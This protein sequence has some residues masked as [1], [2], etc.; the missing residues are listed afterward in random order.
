M[1]RL[2]TIIRKE[3]EEVFRNKMVLASVAL[4][5]L[6]F[7]GIALGTLGSLSMVEMDSA[8]LEADSEE[9]MQLAGALCEGMGGAECLQAYMGGLMMSLFL[10]LPVVLP[11]VF[12]AYSVVGEKTSRTLEPL[13]ATPITTTELLGGKAIAAVLPAVLSTWMGAGLYIGLAWLTIAPAAAATLTAPHWLAALL[14]LSP[15]LAILSVLIAM[16]VSSRVDDPRAAQQ[17][18]GMVVIPVIL[19]LMGQSF[20][21]LVIDGTLVFIGC[22]LL[23]LV[24][25]ALLWLTVRLFERET[26]LTRWK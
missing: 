4:T 21:L 11:G 7:V 26:I 20:G 12:A 18:S 6:V 15:L 23:V 10:V 16:I 25:A 17:I 5:P 13:L 3:W 1:S 2:G 14:L 8:K 22:G 24:D 9:I 19:G